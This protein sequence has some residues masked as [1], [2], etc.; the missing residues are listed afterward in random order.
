MLGKA[1]ASPHH[2]SDL[3]IRAFSASVVKEVQRRAQRAKRALMLGKVLASAHH[4]SDPEI[5][6]FLASAFK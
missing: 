5:R 3:E 2:N 6:A 4:N 1:L